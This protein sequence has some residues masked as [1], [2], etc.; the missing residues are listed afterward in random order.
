MRM[1]SL[2]Y[3]QLVAQVEKMPA[4]PKSVQRVVQLTSNIG[5][6]A[7][8]IVQVIECD[9]VLTVKILKVINSAFY[10]LSH[11]INTVQRAVVHLGL[12]TVK[13]LA[14]S[15]AAIGMLKNSNKADFNP[16]A[17]LLHALTTAA[18]SRKLAE[19][20]GLSPQ[21][22]SDCFVAGLLHDFGKIVF[23]EF[24]PER[25]KLALAKS[26]EDNVPLHLAELEFIGINHA[27]AGTLLAEKWGLSELLSE[28]IRHHHGEPI[29]AFGE[30]LFAANQISKQLHLG[31]GGNPVVE[32]FPDAIASRF[33]LSLEPL[34]D[35]L[36]NLAIIALEAEL[37]IK[38]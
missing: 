8:E 33:G 12:N 23:A 17:F 29:N 21:E 30:C 20:A 1:D 24:M 26:K 35:D 16:T 11:K 25:F 34:I 18:I 13:N 27:D 28:A 37:F 32:A 31:D 10:G 9:P 38:S 3:A 6:S 36:G 15:V 7:K 4:F 14:M 19:R 22:C 5:V 2:N